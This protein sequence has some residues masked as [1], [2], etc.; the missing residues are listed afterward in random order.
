MN[1]HF[2][3]PALIAAAVQLLSLV[4]DKPANKELEDAARAYLIREFTQD[5][6]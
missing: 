5:K 2:A 1:E 4:N 3:D 6:K